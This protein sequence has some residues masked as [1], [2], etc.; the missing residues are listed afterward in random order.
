[1]INKIIENCAKML[2]LNVATEKYKTCDVL[3]AYKEGL[4]I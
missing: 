1:M 2:I 3:N 4:A